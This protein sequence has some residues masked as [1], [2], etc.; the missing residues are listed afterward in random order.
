MRVTYHINRTGTEGPGFVFDQIRQAIAEAGVL[1]KYRY[2]PIHDWAEFDRAA[3]KVLVDC[4]LLVCPLGGL[5]FQIPKAKRMGIK[6]LAIEFSTHTIHRDKILE[7]ISRR[8]SVNMTATP[9]NLARALKVYEQADYFLVLSEYAKSTYCSHGIRPDQ[10]FVAHPG[11]DA[12]KFAFA[13]PQVTPFRVLFVASNALR[14]G[15]PYLLQAWME[16]ISEGLKGELFIR[17]GV[18]SIPHSKN[19]TLVPQWL[20]E[21]D[22]ADLYRSCSITILPSLEDG[23]GVTNL[24]SMACGRAVISTP[25]GID[26]IMTEYVEGILIPPADVKAIKEAIL[27]FYNNPNEI[28]SMGKKARQLA[29]QYPWARFRA[30]V[31]EVVKGLSSK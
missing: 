17:T 13:E 10:V 8:Y 7:P 1:Y 22:L 29:E 2:F 11:I 3:K 9:A 16:L 19:I 20:S 18:S 31:G 14:K 30:R 25:M 4:D 5:T 28:V 27:Y 6:T 12:D 24:E 15:L 21:A 26:D 23:F